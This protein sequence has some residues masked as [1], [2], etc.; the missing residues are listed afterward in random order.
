MKKQKMLVLTFATL[1]ALSTFGL[2]DG[3]GVKANAAT[4]SGS[5]AGTTTS[6]NATV[7]F[8]DAN[9]KVIGSTLAGNTNTS[10]VKNFATSTVQSTMTGIDVYSGTNVTDWNAVKN[11]GVTAV[12][13]KLTD[14]LTYNNPNA[15]AQYNGAKSAGLKVGAYHY[16]ED[17]D[18]DSE[19]SH[20]QSQASKYQWDLKPVLDYEVGGNTDL[21]FISTFMA[22]DSNLI[23]YSS[24][25]VADATGLPINRI[26]V[27][28]PSD[29]GGYAFTGTTKGYAGIQ[30]LW[31][32]TINGLQG[33]A[34]VDLFSND[35]LL[36]PQLPS[37]ICVDK[38]LINSATSDS[39][40]ISG[41]SLNASGNK[42]VDILV[43][44]KENG[45]AT[46][47]QP[48]PDVTS[49]Y[50]LYGIT[51][52][53]F[54][55]NLDTSA[56][57][58]GN[59]TITVE[60]IG[61]DG[62]SAIQNVNVTKLAP[63]LSVDK[64]SNNTTIPDSLSISGWSLNISGNKV[65]NIL[66]DGKENGTATLGQP[67][68][69]VVPVHPLYGI[70]NSGFSYTLNAS[71]L[72][73]GNHTITVQS[74]GNDGN[75]ASQNINIVRPDPTVS[76]SAIGVTYRTQAQN[77]GWQP[78]V[79][80]GEEAGTVG[81]GL[82]L[83]T[84]NIKLLNAPAGASIQYQG[85]VQNIGWQP[86]VSDGANAGTVGLGL[87]LETLRIKLVNMPGYSVQYQA[88]VQNIGWQPLVSDGADAGTVGPGLRLEAIRIKIVPV[89]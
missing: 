62:N 14:G 72:S 67:R 33:D 66:V 11:A 17:N 1:L 78:Y 80:S 26:W 27:A 28:E 60:S 52:S 71:S 58:Y 12:Y 74:T 19:Y 57:S 24:H 23:F 77:I 83:E 7:P 4:V 3:Q 87:R 51:N 21:N 5:N 44:G 8:L 15:L 69:D 89:K 55:Y 88:Q 61:N 37:L 82:R 16:A 25:T 46:L 47:G 56:L 34:D 30:Y 59:H 10:Q 49:I 81:Q 65:V 53:G 6:A 48:R 86:L 9:G 73:Y 40:S 29:A 20:F 50:P 36:A 45:T 38:P 32:G 31:H 13:I 54:S 70:T 43:D 39:L 64:P 18:V 84:L 63:L 41:W 75:S 85:Q 2:L 68:P 42:E 22:K 35:I 79:N 76:A